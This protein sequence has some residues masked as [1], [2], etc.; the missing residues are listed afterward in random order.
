[1]TSARQ[2][3]LERIR[4][5]TGGSTPG[6]EAEYAAVPR[7]YTCAGSLGTDEKL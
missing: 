3:I 6:R 2:E 1:M 5:A 7:D 4:N